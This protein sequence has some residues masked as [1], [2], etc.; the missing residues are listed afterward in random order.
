MASK[1][2]IASAIFLGF[3]LFALAAGSDESRDA[4]NWA[5]MREQMVEEIERDMRSAR[6]YVGRD[7]LSEPV[8]KA[9]KSVERHLFVGDN[10]RRWAYDNAPLPIG[11][12]QTISQPFIV[13]LM[14]EL[15]DV[16]TESKVLEVGTGSGYQAAVLAE[17][18]KDVYTIEI[19]GSLADAAS[20]RLHALG[21]T[22][23]HVK[24]GDGTL[25]WPDEAPFDAIV[26]TAAGINIPRTLLDQLKPGAR[27]VMPVGAE[28]ATQQLMV[29]T[30]NADGSF[31]RR[32]TIPVRFVPITGDNAPK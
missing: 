9:M 29:V 8:L 23:V 21:Y 14:T 10:Y 15:L 3:P 1:F 20:K 19:V 30:R 4:R 2:S 5:V 13:A 28:N 26:V 22:N 27:L 11:E 18:V 24:Q 6:P 7:K 31:I 25:G 17:I 12:G 32:K 16:D